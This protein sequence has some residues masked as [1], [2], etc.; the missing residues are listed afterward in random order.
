MRDREN[1]I[2]QKLVTGL[3]NLAGTANEG[4]FKDTILDGRWSKNKSRKSAVPLTEKWIVDVG[5]RFE[6]TFFLVSLCLSCEVNVFDKQ[7]S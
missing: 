5:R 6:S 7:L 2:K 3:F 1:A 4:V